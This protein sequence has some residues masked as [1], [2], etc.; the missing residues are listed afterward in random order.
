MK[1]LYRTVRLVLHAIA[2]V[3][4]CGVVFPFINQEAKDRYVRKWSAKLMAISGVTMRIYHAERIAPRSLI[5]SNHIS[6]LDIFLI[7]SHFNGHFIAK[8]T[9]ANWPVMGYLGK[10]VGTLYLD[11]SSGRNLKQI[12]GRLVGNLND[13][14][15][16][17]FFPEGTTAKQGEML[18]FFPN[19]FEGAIQVNL[20]IQPFAIRYI[21][22][23]GSY[24][25]AVDFS[26]DVSMQESM[27]R[28]FSADGITAELTV[29]PPIDPQ[30]KT[31]RELA[32]ASQAIIQST[33]GNQT[34][35][36]PGNPV[37]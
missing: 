36:E 3:F 6:W 21:M 31:R 1:R 8:S 10:K 5:V 19:L 25:E 14:E 15:R 27:K 20:P 9:M 4:Y 33:I 13:E 23:D 22:P 17:I 34:D 16:C 2:A 28:I 32:Q 24:A 35:S 7:Y 12:L 18:P 30:G 37:A 26:G 11:R 29:L